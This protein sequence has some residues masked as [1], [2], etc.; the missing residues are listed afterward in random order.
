[1]VRRKNRGKQRVLGPGGPSFQQSVRPLRNVDRVF[2]PKCLSLVDPRACF[3]VVP[4]GRGF[5]VCWALSSGISCAPGLP[6][7]DCGEGRTVGLDGSL[8]CP[9]QARLS[10]AWSLLPARC[11][12][13]FPPTATLSICLT[14][15]LIFH[16][17]PARLAQQGRSLCPCQVLSHSAPSSPGRIQ[18]LQCGPNSLPSFPNTPDCKARAIIRLFRKDGFILP[19]DEGRVLAPEW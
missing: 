10:S 6:W 8:T 18:C 4:K 7:A 19:G 2:P 1:M 17:G 11:G 13:C 15:S 12:Q 16:P 9:G 3:C 5:V 14:S